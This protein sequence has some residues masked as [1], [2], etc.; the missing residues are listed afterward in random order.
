MA[1]VHQGVAQ[2]EPKYPKEKTEL[3]GKD[4]HVEQR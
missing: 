1:L 3:H 4:L 2:A